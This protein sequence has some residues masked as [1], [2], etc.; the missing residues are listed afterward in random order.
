MGNRLSLK[1]KLT[2]T[3]GNFGI[4]TIGGIH[5]LYLVYFFF[6][7][8]DKG[9]PYVVPQKTFFL[10][11]TILGLIL[12]ASRIFDAI[13]DPIIANR[14][15]NSKHKLG[16][17]VPFL[18]KYALLTA[19]AHVLVFFV[20]VP[21]QVHVLNTIWLAVLMFLIAI[22]FTLYSVPYYSLMVEMAKDPHDKIDL[23]TMHSFF[24]FT[25][26]LISSFSS[27]SW[28]MISNLLNVSTTTSI[29]ISFVFLA[30]LSAIALLIPAFT[31]DE[32]KY[33]SK[34][35]PV[36]KPEGILHS[37][38][39]VLGNKN[40]LVYIIAN[41]TYTLSTFMFEAGLLYF[42]TV[43]ARKDESVQGLLT[44][45][46]G[47]LTLLSYPLINKIAK[48]KGKKFIM[49]LGFFMFA[50]TFI[51][52][53]LLGLG[54]VSVEILLFLVILIAPIPQAIFGILPPAMVADC[55]AYDMHMTGEDH[56]AMFM[57][58][59]SF[60]GKLGGSLATVL[61][62]SF[63]VFGKDPGHDLGIR[64]ATIAGAILSMASMFIIT[65]YNEKEVM[66]YADSYRAKEM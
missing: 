6:P 27:G 22:F 32:K 57:A 59:N 49:K 10:G 23:A 21:G 35:G 46:I 40:F 30:I 55:A 61:F 63:L 16:K 64:I 38:K 45:L 56:S 60:F 15:D 37:M 58:V 26:F 13:T 17:R 12:A 20:P 36:K 66:T 41:T 33:A 51:D 3:V 4:G 24:W 8:K 5:M 50:L 65:R 9:I 53:T 25:G 52:I 14:S 19:A 31:I 11:L 54:L 2:Y 39:K 18:R 42:V 29:K 47:G 48:A 28:D 44:T 62:T 34:N 7:P 1:E 43:L